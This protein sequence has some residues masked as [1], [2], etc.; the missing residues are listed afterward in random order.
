MPTF[1]TYRKGRRERRT[2]NEN[3]FSDLVD[4][5]TFRLIRRSS[6]ESTSSGV[7][8]ALQGIEVSVYISVCTILAYRLVL[9]S[10][11]GKELVLNHELRVAS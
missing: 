11:E 5:G 9:Q 6:E 4:L 10:G 1:L 3:G 7:P 8:L 2:G